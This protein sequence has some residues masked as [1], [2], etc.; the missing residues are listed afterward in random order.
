MQVSLEENLARVVYAPAVLNP[1]RIAS[2]ID[3]MGFTSKVSPLDQGTAPHICDSIVYISGMT[4]KSCVNNIETAMSAVAGIMSISVSLAES[5]ARVRHNDAIITAD[6]IRNRINAMGTKFRASLE[7]QRQSEHDPA[8]SGSDVTSLVVH[9]DGMTCQSCVVNIEGCIS[10]RSGVTSIA[11]SLEG[12]RAQIHYNPALTNPEE[13]RSAI[14]DMGF[15]ASLSDKCTLSI[16]GMT[17][18]SCVRNIEGKIGSL[19]W[20]ESVTV[21]LEEK[22]A[23]IYYEGTRWTPEKLAAEIEDMGFESKPVQGVQARSAVVGIVGMTCGSCVANIERAVSEREGVLS[24]RVVL[25]EEKG[26]VTYNG[27]VLNAEN[28]AQII[29]DMG[30]EATVIDH[31]KQADHL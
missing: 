7:P 10:K 4:C 13:L 8:D 31:G 15:D 17:C 16:E 30:F 9:I 19:A 22:Q 20:V 24:V 14:D 6:G 2:Y 21:S 23:V 11:V 28:I 12:S 29:D 5:L 25:A 1:S 26:Y 3:D 18:M 27:A